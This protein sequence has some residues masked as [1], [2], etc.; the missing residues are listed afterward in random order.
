M[1]ANSEDPGPRDLA[2]VSAFDAA[3]AIIFE[4]TMTLRQYYEDLRNLVD[5]DAF[6]AKRGIRKITAQLYD[7]RGQ[8]IEDLQNEYSPEGKFLR[9]PQRQG[10]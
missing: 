9:N 7:A 5:D 4:R 8:L 3:G 1:T 2:L 6:R 10:D